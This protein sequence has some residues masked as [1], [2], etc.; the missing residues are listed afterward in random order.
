ME[1]FLRT[2]EAA[3]R[4]GLSARTFR[5]CV[6]QAEVQHFS[7]LEG[8]SP[9]PKAPLKNGLRVGAEKALQIRGRQC[10]A[11]LDK[12]ACSDSLL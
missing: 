8:W 5:K 2:K 10:H 11:E 3:T 12:V 6:S 4:L 9:I 1:S 7:K